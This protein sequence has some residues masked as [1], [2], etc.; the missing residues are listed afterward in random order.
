M[1]YFNFPKKYLNNILCCMDMLFCIV[2]VAL[3]KSIL[4]L[5]QCNIQNNCKKL[6][7]TCNE[8][9]ARESSA[10]LFTD[11]PVFS[12]SFCDDEAVI[13]DIIF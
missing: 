2:C 7:R 11:P 4:I 6:L 9:D 12:T 5:L 3:L 8:Y 13:N 10:T 1:K